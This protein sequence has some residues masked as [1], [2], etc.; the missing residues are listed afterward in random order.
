MFLLAQCEIHV[1]GRGKM[2]GVDRA[3]ALKMRTCIMCTCTLCIDVQQF[4]HLDT[5]ALDVIRRAIASNRFL[6]TMSVGFVP[7]NVTVTGH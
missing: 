3:L 7:M 2:G 5:T 6:A 1:G 4:V